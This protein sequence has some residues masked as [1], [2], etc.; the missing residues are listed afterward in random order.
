[1][2]TTS[3]VLVA[4]ALAALVLAS[5]GVQAAQVSVTVTDATS[6][7]PINKAAV[8]VVVGNAI[9]AYGITPANG[10]WSK[11]VP[12]AEKAFVVVAKKLYAAQARQVALSGQVPASF[13]LAKFGTDDF[14]RLGRIVG[15]VR[16]AAGE[17]IPNATLVLLKGENAVG[18]T[19]VQNATG[20]Y[21]LEWYAPGTY[22]VVATAEGYVPRTYQRQEIEAGGSLWLDVDLQPR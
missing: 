12:D 8:A 22:T 5:D 3:S 9:V 18:V 7:A 17:A 6:G 11:Q 13:A 21:E 15:F 10:Q 19:R 20:L 4:A 16:N 14:N 2:R 1:M